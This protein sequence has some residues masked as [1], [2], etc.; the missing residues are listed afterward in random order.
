M[1]INQQ[2]QPL[3][4]R[5][6]HGINS[7]LVIACV[8]TGFLVYDSWD[9]RFGKLGLTVEN[10]S[11]IDIHGTF[12]FVLFFVFLGFLIVSI[13]IGRNRL[14]KSDD[15][16]KLT[17]KVGENIWWYRLHRIVNT[18]ILLSAILS[19]GSGKL[20]DENWL[21]NGE[22]NHF[23]YYVHLIGWLIMLLA[24]ATHLLMSAKVGGMPLILSMFETKYRPQ[25]SPKLWPEK[26][27]RWLRHPRW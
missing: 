10:R 23:W 8:I 16:G 20:Q 5:L 26:I 3:L 6:F 2:Y 4:L 1:K 15:L 22:M 17:N 25:E 14:V 11:L 27:R 13:K 9:G 7:F 12:A 21:P 24:I 18:T 19:I